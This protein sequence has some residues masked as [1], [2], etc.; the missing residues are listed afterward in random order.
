MTRE[1]R[2]FF[3]NLTLEN[4]DE[5]KPK[6]VGYAAVF[7][8]DSVDFMFFREVIRSGAFRRSL[9]EKGDVRA[10]LDHDTGKIIARTKAGSLTLREDDRGLRCE[11]EPIDT[12]DGRKAL[13]WVRSGVVD[14]MSFGFETREDK[15]GT[16][17]GKPYRELLDVELYEVSLVAFPAYPATSVDLRSATQV[18]EDRQKEIT[19]SRAKFKNKFRILSLH[20][21]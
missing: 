11:I 7:D 16:K 13:E 18:W 4:R 2:S 3:D 15:W 19:H 14:G 8:S 17:D 6:I 10:L 20:G 12:E 9:Q 1:I 21:S 5:Q